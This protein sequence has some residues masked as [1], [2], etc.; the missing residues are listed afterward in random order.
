MLSHSALTP[1]HVVL[2]KVQKRLAILLAVLGDWAAFI[3]VVLILGLGTSWYMID[4]GTP[5]T[6]ERQGPWTSWTSAGRADADPY[7]RAHFA[8]YGTLPF[9]AELSLA[10]VAFADSDGRRLH[11]SC[12]YSVEGPE[13]G[14]SWWSLSVF[15]DR[16]AADRQR[17][18]ALRLHQ[19]VDRLAARRHVPR[20][21]CARRAAGQLAADGRRRPSRAHVHHARS[22]HPAP[23][24]AE[25][26][27]KAAPHNPPGPMPLN[28]REKLQH[29]NWQLIIAAPIAAGI[30]HICA[31]H[32][33]ALSHRRLRLQP[34]GAGAA[35]QQHAGAAHAV[36][37]G[38]EPLPFLSPDARYAMCHFDATQGPVSVNGD[39]AGRRRAGCSAVISP[40]GDNIYAAASTPGRPT[41][42]T[43][44]LRAVGGAF[45][46]RHAGGARH[47]AR[48]A[49]AGRDRGDA[50]DRRG[51]RTRQGPVLPGG[52]E[53]GSEEGALLGRTF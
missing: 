40:Q 27:S 28:L 33:R 46:R 45:S 43:L 50:W 52:V 25:R 22:E 31:T 24:A 5:L 7:T 36:A 47:R 35:R 39:A 13:P 53:A 9:S 20:H 16:G 32:G 41:P 10:Y 4:I 29:A 42:I 23:V 51:A 48:C 44:V 37:P 15:D 12:D 19:P 8:R 18:P 38:A 6:T 11:S 21:A 49:T 26:R 30:L 1:L 3:G 34:A 14:T 2:H 17:R